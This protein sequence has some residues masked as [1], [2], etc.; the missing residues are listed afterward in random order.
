MSPVD[1]RNSLR[2]RRAAEL[3][4]TGR[5]TVGE[6]AKQVGI[7]DIKYFGKLFKRYTGINPGILKKTDDAKYHIKHTEKTTKTYQK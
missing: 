6:A 5:F 3:L 7:E 2:I 4:R 1:Y